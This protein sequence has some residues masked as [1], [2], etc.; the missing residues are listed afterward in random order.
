MP[1]SGYLSR[2]SQRIPAAV[3]SGYLCVRPE[4]VWRIPVQRAVPPA[5][6]G[7]QSKLKRAAWLWL[8]L[9]RACQTRVVMAFWLRSWLVVAQVVAFESV[10][11][12]V[13][14]FIHLCQSIAP[15][16]S[17]KTFALRPVMPNC[18]KSATKKRGGS[19]RFELRRPSQARANPG[20]RL[21]FIDYLESPGSGSRS[22]TLAR[23]RSNFSRLLNAARS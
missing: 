1:H 15:S 19:A 3:V 22:R 8:P 17:V 11:P 18:G 10:C 12:T 2:V 13:R 7:R 16:I 4:Q 20:W 21:R 23:T 6:C 9:R 5:S 14:K